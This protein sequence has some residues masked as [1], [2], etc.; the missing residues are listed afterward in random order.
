MRFLLLIVALMALVLTA[1]GCG[2]N[3][4]PPALEGRYEYT[5]TSEEISRLKAPMTETELW[6]ME[7][8]EELKSALEFNGQRWSRFWIVD[9]EVHPEFWG[10]EEGTFTTDADRLI[11]RAQPG[12]GNANE[13]YAWTLDDGVLSLT[14]VELGERFGDPDGIRLNTEHEF[15]SSSR[16]SPGLPRG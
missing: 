16:G 10:R 9:G 6:S 7:G 12:T 5:F 13:T 3:D 8:V 11:L 2:G 14:F 1:A 4:A 15:M